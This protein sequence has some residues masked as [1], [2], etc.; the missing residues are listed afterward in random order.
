MKLDIFN[1]K[2]EKTGR[3][4]ELSDAVFGIEP[5]QHVV[6]LAVKAYLANQRQG[7]HK[8]KERSEISGSTRKLH[9]QKGTGG[10]RKGSIKNPLYHGGPRVFGPR[11]RSYEQFLNKKVK[12]LARRSALAAKA[13]EGQIII[14]EDFT[15]DQPKT[16]NYQG[17]LNALKVGDR[18]TLHVVAQRD[19]N[20][21][22][23]SRNLPKAGMQLAQDLHTYQIVVSNTL[24][25]SESAAQFIG[26]TFA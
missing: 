24:V 25:I 12:A 13:K 4:I 20:L 16:K 6:Y 19:E 7:T 23:A 18:K 2:G 9:K 15:L 1:I 8:A 10:S 3:T 11:P 22:R 17:I 21:L 14:V 5:N 26:Q